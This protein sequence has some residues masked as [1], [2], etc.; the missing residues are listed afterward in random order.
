MASSS[1]M[2]VTE[3]MFA[4]LAELLGKAMCG[5]IERAG[6]EFVIGYREG[7]DVCIIA[8]GATWDLALAQATERVQLV[9]QL[10]RNT[11]T[12][13]AAVATAASVPVRFVRLRRRDFTPPPRVRGDKSD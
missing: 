3:P 1:G 12:G 6:E 4:T 10:V 7:R 5:S 13:N 8:R 9:D 11:S 2:T